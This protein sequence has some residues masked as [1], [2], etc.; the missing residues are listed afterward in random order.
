M[1]TWFSVC[2]QT[3]STIFL[4][5]KGV[6]PTP[7]KKKKKI[8]ATLYFIC[9]KQI[10]N[11]SDE[12]ERQRP[13]SR[14]RNLNFILD[15]FNF[16]LFLRPRISIGAF[17]SLTFLRPLVSSPTENRRRSRGWYRRQ[18]WIGQALLRCRHHPPH[19]RTT[20][21]HYRHS[22]IYSGDLKP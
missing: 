17:K 10:T 15:A 21:Q 14:P 4:R 16:L 6:K 22:G 18:W 13:R 11:K 20:P 9:F 3:N 2:I 1:Y 8:L 7:P 19:S 5:S 12:F